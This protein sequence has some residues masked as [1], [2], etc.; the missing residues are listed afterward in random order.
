MLYLW[1][2]LSSVSPQLAFH[3]KHSSS[4]VLSLQMSL[5]QSMV[6]CSEK[7]VT[8]GTSEVFHLGSLGSTIQHSLVHCRNLRTK[9]G[10]G[11]VTACA[12]TSE[13]CRPQQFRRLELFLWSEYRQFLWSKYR[14][15]NSQR[16]CLQIGPN[17]HLQQE[18]VSFYDEFDWYTWI[19]LHSWC[20]VLALPT[21]AIFQLWETWSISSIP[22]LHNPD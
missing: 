15:S 20:T 9:R 2:F 10:F 22:A 8:T 3:E 19:F 17:S 13:T 16:T 4:S 11:A 14:N 7:A 12:P 5:P 1:Q 6:P 18:E 21:S